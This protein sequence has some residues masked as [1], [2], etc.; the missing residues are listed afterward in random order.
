MRFRP[1]IHR[2]EEDATGVREKIQNTSK[3]KDEAASVLRGTRHKRFTSVEA[4]A[5]GVSTEK[6][7]LDNYERCENA[8]LVFLKTL[9]G[10]R[11]GAR[12]YGC[13]R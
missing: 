3:P 5:E 13:V 6:F 2:I 8:T 9:L 10:L 11:I 4:C 1:T 12:V 7:C